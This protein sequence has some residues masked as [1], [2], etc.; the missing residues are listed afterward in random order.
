[1]R[2]VLDST[3]L[4]S[5]F[6]APGRLSDELL[7]LASDGLFVLVLSDAIIAETERKLLT[8]KNIRRKSSH[9]DS[10]ALDYG[11]ALRELAQLMVDL[12]QLS[13]AVRDPNDDMVIACAIGG[14]AD[15][16]VTRD[17]DL[18][19]LRFYQQTTIVTPETFRSELRRLG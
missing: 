2:A 19:V 16:I 12:P 10:D 14:R 15:R 1:M 11:Q 5:A 4:I 9:T 8:G 18:L 3:V 6:M 7:R 13:G 17:K